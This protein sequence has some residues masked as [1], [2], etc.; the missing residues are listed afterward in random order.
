[1]RKIVKDP[2]RAPYPR[3]TTPQTFYTATRPVS[4]SNLLYTHIIYDSKHLLLYAI[5]IHSYPPAGMC[6]YMPLC[7]SLSSVTQRYLAAEDAHYFCLSL[8]EHLWCWYYLF[9]NKLQIGHNT[10]WTR[11]SAACFD[12]HCKVVMMS[13]LM[14]AVVWIFKS[15]S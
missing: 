3:L 1:M 13:P 2:H 9:Y 8:T 4:R 11:S 12:I 7:H 5:A 15:F 6:S 10:V 14:S